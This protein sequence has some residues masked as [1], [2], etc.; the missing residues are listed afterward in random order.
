MMGQIVDRFT[1]IQRAIAERKSAARAIAEQGERPLVFDCRGDFPNCVAMI[2]RHPANKQWRIFMFKNAECIGDFSAGYHH[3]KGF[4][5][6]VLSA[7]EDFGADLASV[8][9]AGEEF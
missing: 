6:L 8:R 3:W 1:V 7:A 5:G 9:N 2:A 4:Y